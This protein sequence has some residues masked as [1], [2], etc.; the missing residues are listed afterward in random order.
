MILIIRPYVTS[1]IRA[2]EK[3]AGDKPV[4]LEAFRWSLG[5]ISK[6][7]VQ[8]IHEGSTIVMKERTRRPVD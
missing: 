1:A 3:T 6:A 4:A 7:I 8:T 2:V 5:L